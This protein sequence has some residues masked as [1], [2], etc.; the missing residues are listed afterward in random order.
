MEICKIGIILKVDWMTNGKSREELI[1]GMG[2][3]YPGCNNQLLNGDS[4]LN[5]L[6]SKNTF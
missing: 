2:Q 3:E 4:S 6:I 5:N 1:L